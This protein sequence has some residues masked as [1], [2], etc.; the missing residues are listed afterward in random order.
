MD[1]KL[2]DER[3]AQDCL[4]VMIDD[5]Y[6]DSWQLRTLY[7]KCRRTANESLSCDSISRNSYEIAVCTDDKVKPSI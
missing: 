5:D 6:D 4:D 1:E 2:P 7:R 3:E